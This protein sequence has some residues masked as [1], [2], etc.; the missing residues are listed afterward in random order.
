MSRR[1]I[2][3]LS[4]LA[5]LALVGGVAAGLLAA[6]DPGAGPA[7]AEV[8]VDPA[9]TAAPDTSEPPSAASTA[10]TATTRS[11]TTT[12]GALVVQARVAQRLEDGLLVGWAASAPVAATLTWGF[13]SAEGNRVAIPGVAR[14][15]TVKLDLPRTTQPV[16]FR[17]TGQAA[18]GRTASSRPASGR[19][20]VRRVTLRV[21][22]LT[23]DIPNGTA[24]V[25]T[26]F[27]GASLTPLG[28][29][30]AGPTAS[31]EPYAF[32]ATAVS[33]DADAATLDVQ[34]SHQA[35]P[36]RLRTATVQVPV[37]FPE[38]GRSVALTRDAT[39]VGLT[40]HLALQVTVS[41]S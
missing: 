1:A 9:T 41:L 7:A 35:P 27:L 40:V 20:L 5:A 30:L 10:S 18:D 23:L 26:T 3:V 8:P 29:G 36:G 37:D 25:T 15:G 4:L 14:Q 16:T 38:P 19:R 21:T 22:S 11:S 39:R 24:G 17:V 6:R 13:S 2:V 28:P 32:P 33:A 31:S 34:L 12:T